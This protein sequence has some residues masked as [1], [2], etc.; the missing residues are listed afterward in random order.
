MACVKMLKVAACVAG[1]FLGW[2]V[3]PAGG[4]V[5]SLGA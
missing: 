5:V 3:F 2:V 4:L 1:F